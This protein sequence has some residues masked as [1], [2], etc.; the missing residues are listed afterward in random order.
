M[1]R[2]LLRRMRQRALDPLLRRLGPVSL[3]ALLTTLVLLFGFRG[4]AT[5]AQPVVIAMLPVPILI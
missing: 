5:L 1:G 4:K 3:V 2:R